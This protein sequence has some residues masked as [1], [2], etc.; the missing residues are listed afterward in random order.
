MQKSD[1]ARPVLPGDTWSKITVVLLDR[2]VAYLDRIAVDI[3]LQRGV[4]IS[5][6]DLIRALIEAASQS[7][8]T[9]SDAP[10]NQ[11][12]MEILRDAWAR[13]RQR[14]QR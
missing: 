9:L 4:A 2:Q 5:R 8:L 11:Q 3:R 1:Q 10:A 6:A 14:K 13:G 12:R 7:G